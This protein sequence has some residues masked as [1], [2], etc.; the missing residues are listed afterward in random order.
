MDF[1]YHPAEVL[2]PGQTPK[3]QKPRIPI[4]PRINPKLRTK[5]FRSF[6]YRRSPYFE[7]FDTPRDEA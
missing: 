7:Y 4:D 2:S 6:S 3:Q 5:P 1:I